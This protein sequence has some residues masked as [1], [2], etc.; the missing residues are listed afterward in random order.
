MS[1]RLLWIAAILLVCLVVILAVRVRPKPFL[2]ERVARATALSRMLSSFNEEIANRAA[3]Y[4]AS[5]YATFDVGCS[6]TIVGPNAVLTAGHCA[7]WSQNITIEF[8]GDNFDAHCIPATSPLDIAMCRL[9]NPVDGILFDVIEQ[10]QMPAA[11][12]QTIVLTGWADPPATNPFQQLLQT[13]RRSFGFP[14]PFRTGTG[15]I[16]SSSTTLVVEGN[17]DP[18]G[19]VM[20]ILPGDSGGAGYAVQGA[21]RTIIGV[22]VCGGSLCVTGATAATS[23]LTNVTDPTVFAWIKTWADDNGGQVCGYNTTTDCRP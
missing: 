7:D 22:N 8:N 17:A 3:N 2:F 4:P 21:H 5:L 19:Q 13:L 20:V 1:K 6:A 18:S 14:P 11:T 15:T 23:V 16:K 10:N 9:D 12:G